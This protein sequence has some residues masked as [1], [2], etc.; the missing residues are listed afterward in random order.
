MLQ[1]FSGLFTSVRATGRISA[2]RISTG[3]ISTIAKMDINILLVFNFSEKGDQRR[4]ISPSTLPTNRRR[5][6]LSLGL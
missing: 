3:C 2:C 4:Q 1:E 5:K 6:R